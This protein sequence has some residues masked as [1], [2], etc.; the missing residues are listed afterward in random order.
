M[1]VAVE[2][3]MGYEFASL[4][5][6]ELMSRGQDS[7]AI[8]KIAINREKAKYLETATMV[9][10]GVP[11]DFANLRPGHYGELGGVSNDQLYGSPYEDAYHRDFTINAL[12]YNIRTDSVEDY[13]GKGL[14]DLRNGVIRTPLRA[15]ETFWQDPLRVIRCI[16]FAAG[17]HFQ[18]AEDTKQAML[19]PRIKEA[20]RTK[21]S[22]ERVGAEL[23]KIIRDRRGRPEAMRLLWEMGLFDE[24]IRQPVTSVLV[25]GVSEIRG[26]RS[27]TEDAFKL[28]WIMEWL[29][30]INGDVSG[31]GTEVHNDALFQ[32]ELDAGRELLLKQT[33]D[34]SIAS[35]LY[36]LLTEEPL[37]NIPRHSAPKPDVNPYRIS[38][39]N[40][41]YGSMLYPYRNVIVTHNNKQMPASSWIYK[42]CL[43]RRSIDIHVIDTFYQHIDSVRMLVDSLAKEPPLDSTQQL[44]SETLEIGTWIRQV[45]GLQAVSQRWPCIAMFGLGV[46]LLPKFELL[47][48][49]ILDEASRATIT[50][51]NTLL[52]RAQSYQISDCF[53]WRHIIDDSELMKTYGILAGPQVSLLLG[54]MMRWQ[55]QHPTSSKDECLAWLVA[56]H[57]P[58]LFK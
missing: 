52:S 1:D 5:N 20:L 15:Y 42:H 46:D 17:F 26:T 3:M 40:L 4:V 25:R 51:Y 39:Q 49:G 36:P 29:T 33:Q 58:T 35:H 32:S 31:S 37:P 23:S 16:R 41:I 27:D 38:E 45:S 28:A 30:R 34:V 21:I 56:R 11:M 55:L 10:H 43:K 50:K 22:P 2:S 9:L 53:S 6:N 24:V 18:I 54:E 7:K 47:K 14:D 57:P 8:A 44:K 12:F 19:D 48:Q 13:T